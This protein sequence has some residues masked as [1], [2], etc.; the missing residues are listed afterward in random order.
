MATD[1]LEGQGLDVPALEPSTEKAL[2]EFLPA[3][4]STRNPV[5]MIASAT[6]EA[7][8]RAIQLLS[9]D[10]NVDSVLAIY[11]P[12]IV[13]QPTEIAEA[14]VRGTYAAAKRAE[15]DGH[16]PKPVVSCFLGS[17]GVPE[18]LR[19]GELCNIPSYSFPE[20]A[21]IALSHAVYYGQWLDATPGAS[22]VFDDL[23]SDRAHAAIQ[24]AL[25]RSKARAWL[26][27]SEVR[28]VLSAYGI[29]TVED[30]EA[31]SADEAA[32]I[33]DRVGYPVAVKLVSDTITHKSEVQGV[34]LDVRDAE[35]V[36][37]AYARIEGRLR[38]LDRLDEM[39]GV[40]VQRMVQGRR[41]G[42]RGRDARSELRPARDVRAR[43][44]VRR[45]A[46][47]RRVP[48]FT[49][50]RIRTRTISCARFAGSDCS[51]ATAVRPRATSAPSR[52]SCFASRGSW[53]TTPRS[54]RWT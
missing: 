27:P 7:F 39:H 31:H 19:S 30:G 44:C 21:A 47:R 5:D 43:W 2:H 26:D 54:S 51:R 28:D 32:A 9:A 52:R 41:G 13:T 6:P 34:H 4:A 50:S 36:R 42:D 15:A 35:G 37:E 8:E 22:P 17:H 29:P 1:A 11:V 33:A 45:S 20:A 49:R 46:Q 16:R 10:P 25:D 48:A 53:A 18:G 3:E 40:A 38:E 23:D 12:P 14:I 24:G